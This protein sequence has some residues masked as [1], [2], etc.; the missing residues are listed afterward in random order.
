MTR[1]RISPLV[2]VIALAATSVWAAAQSV[3][4]PFTFS[5]TSP[6]ALQMDSYGNLSSIGTY[7]TG[8][9][10][11]TGAGTRMFWYPGKA[12]F[13][14]GLVTGTQWNDANIG[15]YSVAFGY[16]TTAS[17]TYSM[18]IG[19]SSIASGSYS[20]SMGDVSEATGTGATALGGSTA[21][22]SFSTA[23]GIFAL[24]SGN[25]STAIGVS[26]TASGNQATAIG[27][28]VQ[29]SGSFSTALGYA[30]IAA[31]YGSCVV[32]QFNVGGGA[33]TSW[34]STDPLFEIGNG[35]SGSAKADAM[36]VYKNG[37]VQVHGTFRCAAGGDISMGSFTAGTTP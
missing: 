32:G 15:A 26:P 25:S 13:R 10:S 16:S 28:D 9:F 22:G 23:L 5:G 29:A 31:S 6:I 21:S 4:V 12:A 3:T 36:V 34:V 33:T 2:F 30:T 17:G 7:G 37:N 18:A 1:N 24:A 19:N 14:A 11:L 27:T 20:V 35:T 8:T